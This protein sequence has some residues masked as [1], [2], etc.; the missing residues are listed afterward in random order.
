MGYASC[1]YKECKS[2]DTCKRFEYDGTIIN[3]KFYY[4]DK[5]GKCMYHIQKDDLLPKV[6]EEEKEV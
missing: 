1:D 2:K 4:D 6:K 3:F 5:K